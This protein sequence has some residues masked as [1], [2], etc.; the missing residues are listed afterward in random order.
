M[1]RITIASVAAS[2]TET[3]RSL[4]TVIA[5]LGA[6]KARVAELEARVRELEC[7]HNRDVDTVHQ[8]AR[9]ERT[10]FHDG[11]QYPLVD[12][13]GRRYRVT[14]INGRTVKCFMPEC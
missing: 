12:R 6:T 14:E 2:L 8:R 4:T 3:V 7:A 13:A 9:A 5:D 1:A 11:V 10:G